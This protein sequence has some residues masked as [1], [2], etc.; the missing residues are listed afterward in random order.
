[1]CGAVARSGLKQGRRG[2][3][4]GIQHSVFCILYSVFCILYSVGE[5][6]STNQTSITLV[7]L[8]MRGSWHVRH[9]GTGP[10]R[11]RL[12]RLALGYSL[13]HGSDAR[14]DTK[15]NE[16][17]PSLLLLLL[18]LPR[19]RH[20]LGGLPSRATTHHT[21]RGL[22]HPAASRHAASRLVRTGEDS[23]SLRAPPARM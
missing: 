23:P 7:S 11:V 5:G 2:R 12:L 20:T 13:P 18:V 4:G 19:D 14:T 16:A 9:A 17:P 6:P 10:L 8:C 1:M 21:T 3:G 15:P 22:A